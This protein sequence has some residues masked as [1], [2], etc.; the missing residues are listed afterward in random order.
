MYSDIIFSANAGLSN[1]MSRLMFM[2]K[3]VHNKQP[4]FYFDNQILFGY[5]LTLGINNYLL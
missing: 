4:F 1:I 3:S 2:T 5:M